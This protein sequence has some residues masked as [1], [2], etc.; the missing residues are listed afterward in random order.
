M[1]AYKL[2]A[3]ER[4]LYQRRIWEWFVGAELV[5]PAAGARRGRLGDLTF[6]DPVLSLRPVLSRTDFWV[7]PGRT[8][9]ADRDE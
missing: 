2:Q 9:A 8:V 3:W 7:R 6:F 4:F 1:N 5:R